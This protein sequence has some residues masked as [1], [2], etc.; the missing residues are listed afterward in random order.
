MSYK[1]ITFEE[2]SSIFSYDPETGDIYRKLK[3]SNAIAVGL[4]SNGENGA[5]YS[6][7]FLFGKRVYIHRLVWL[8]HHGHWPEKQID[9]IDGNRSNNRI[10]N[11]RD[12]DHKINAQNMSRP[13]SNNTAGFL[14]VSYD[15]SREKYVARIS[16]GPR[17]NAYNKYL[18]RY[19][20]AE[21]AHAAYTIAKSKLHSGYIEQ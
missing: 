14:G 21:E 9:H 6:R 7:V 12:V 13:Q 3:T 8:L 15:K 1:T 5:G 4:V 10:T 18:G 16:I 17:G 11:L 20:T 19:E 2:A